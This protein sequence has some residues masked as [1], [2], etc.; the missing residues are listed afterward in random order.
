MSQFITH[1]EFCIYT[2]L[3]LL[4]AELFD[5]RQL[6]INELS[7]V[8]IDVEEQSFLFWLITQCLTIDDTAQ[9]PEL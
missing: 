3:P 2:A 4:I 9:I 6:S 5:K 1:D 7:N 8:T